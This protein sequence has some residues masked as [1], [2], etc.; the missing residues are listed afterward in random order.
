VSVS[1][2]VDDSDRSVGRSTTRVRVAVGCRDPSVPE[3]VGNAGKGRACVDELGRAAVAEIVV[4]EVLGDVGMQADRQR[5]LLQLRAEVDPGEDEPA[6]GTHRVERLAGGRRERERARPFALVDLNAHA[7][8]AVA[9]LVVPRRLDTE[10]RPSPKARLPHR[11]EERS[12]GPWGLAGLSCAH[13]LGQ[14]R[15]QRGRVP[16]RELDEHVLLRASPLRVA[17]GA[18]HRGRFDEIADRLAGAPGQEVLQRRAFLLHRRRGHVIE[19]VF[20]VAS[21]RG[22]IAEIGGASEERHPMRAHVVVEGA[23]GVGLLLLHRGEPTAEEYVDVDAFERS[24]PYPRPDDPC[25]RR[26]VDLRRSFLS[27]AAIS[28]ARRSVIST[29]GDGV[30]HT[31]DSGALVSAEGPALLRLIHATMSSRSKSTR[32]PIRTRESLGAT[33]RKKLLSETRQ[34]SAASSRVSKSDSADAVMGHPP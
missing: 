16:W 3:Q 28:S 11:L 33:W 21:E 2:S 32:V 10:E 24:V 17:S 12:A 31:P 18:R 20:D 22:L 6:L 4:P 25:Q 14:L 7:Q 19:A 5:C 13:V 23:R 1:V 15:D 26:C 34:S 27:L 30:T 9:S 8:L 29:T